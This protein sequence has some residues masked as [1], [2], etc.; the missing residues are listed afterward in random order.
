MACAWE[1]TN[2]SVFRAGR[3]TTAPSTS[4]RSSVPMAA[5]VSV[6]TIASAPTTGKAAHAKSQPVRATVLVEAFV[7]SLTNAN[8]IASLLVL[9]V[10]NALPTHGARTV[11][12]VQTVKTVP[13]AIIKQANVIVR[14]TGLA[15]CVTF[16]PMV[17]SDHNAYD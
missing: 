4:A 2:A 16:A 10:N 17:I 6:P 7:V 14:Q 8:A 1:P 9:N 15:I 3:E 5:N 12:H 11:R 13:N